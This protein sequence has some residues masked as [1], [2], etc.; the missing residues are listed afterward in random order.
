MLTVDAGLH[1]E[2]RARGCLKDGVEG[3]VFYYADCNTTRSKLNLLPFLFR[4]LLLSW[5]VY[6]HAIDDP[7]CFARH[8]K[9]GRNNPI[10]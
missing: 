10:Q 6:M 1:G 8:T 9:T 4:L 7:F 2:Q 3:L 5:N